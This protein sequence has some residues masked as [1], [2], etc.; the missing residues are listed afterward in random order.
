MN[1]G[2]GGS[3]ARKL[4]MAMIETETETETH[5]R[6]RTSEETCNRYRRKYEA[7]IE[8]WNA[9]AEEV[10][11]RLGAQGGLEAQPGA[12]AIHRKYEALRSR[13]RELADA[14][15]DTWEAL[16]GN[17]E[18]AWLDFKSSIEGAYDALRSQHMPPRQKN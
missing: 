8:E 5:S 10:R 13:L 16:E 12:E 2:G 15:D 9:R 18:R 17:A 11:A 14:A 6:G 1:Q 7:Q 4:A 3:A